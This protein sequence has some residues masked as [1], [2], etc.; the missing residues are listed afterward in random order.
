M[1]TNITF[2]TGNEEKARMLTDTEKILSEFAADYKRM[3]E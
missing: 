2:L 3:A 1:D